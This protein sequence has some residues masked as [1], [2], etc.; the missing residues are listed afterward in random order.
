VNEQVV[1][2]FVFEDRIDRGE[3]SSSGHSVS[4]IPS[5]RAFSFTCVQCIYASCAC[6]PSL[7]PASVSSIIHVVGVLLFLQRSAMLECTRTQTQH[8]H[9][10]TH[11]Q[12][13]SHMSM[14]ACLFA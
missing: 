4:A 3:S 14:P 5:C 1:D 12:A 6:V 13:R 8:P 11:T 9:T 2:I 7:K 10:Y